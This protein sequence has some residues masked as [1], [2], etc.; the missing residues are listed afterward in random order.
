[1]RGAH[2]RRPY[3]PIAAQLIILFLA[4]ALFGV[5]IAIFTK[6]VVQ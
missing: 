4:L 6:E 3:F 2:Y 5:G 1:M